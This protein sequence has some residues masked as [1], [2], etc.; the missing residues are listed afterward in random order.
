MLVGMRIKSGGGLKGMSK[1][2]N[3]GLHLPGTCNH[4]LR[5]SPRVLDLFIDI[6]VLIILRCGDTGG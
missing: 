3:D 2:G 6:Q 5:S 1:N 4:S